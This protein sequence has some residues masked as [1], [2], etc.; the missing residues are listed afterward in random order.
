MFVRTESFSQYIRS[1][2]IIS[3][4]VAIHIALYVLT[5]IPFLPNYWVFE[6][7]AGVNI[8]IT[9]GEWWRLITPIFVHLG[10]A[11]LAFNSISLII[12]AP[13]LEEFFGKWKFSFLYI[14]AGIVGN[15]ATYIFEPPTYIHVG[16]SGSI[17]GLFGA[18]LAFIFIQKNAV[19]QEMKQVILPIV[20]I[21]L[22]LSVFQPNINLIAHFFGLLGGFGFGYLLF[23]RR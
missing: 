20:L 10:F 19:T 11:H 18:Y 12:F 3:I 15:V 8:Y 6:Q 2:P 5:L 14:M 4:L 22:V 17:F 9:Q 1:Y 13:P 7:L 16:A 23:I 21:G